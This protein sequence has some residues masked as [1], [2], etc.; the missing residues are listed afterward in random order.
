MT[1]DYPNYDY[2]IAIREE[3]SAVRK[4]LRQTLR[5]QLSLAQFPWVPEFEEECRKL[6]DSTEGDRL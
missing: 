1:M 4:L 6:I 2:L 3:L 5:I